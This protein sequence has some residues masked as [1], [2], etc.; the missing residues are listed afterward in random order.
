MLTRRCVAGRDLYFELGQGSPITT[1]FYLHH[2]FPTGTYQRPHI[3]QSRQLP[4]RVERLSL[5]ASGLFCLR[6]VSS[7]TLIAMSTFLFHKHWF[8]S[9]KSACDRA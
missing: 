7:L 6:L 5:I 2:I 8:K 4:I 1:F 9:L 3:L